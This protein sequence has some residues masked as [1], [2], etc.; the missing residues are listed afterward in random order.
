MLLSMDNNKKKGKEKDSINNNK[1][2]EKDLVGPSIYIILSPNISKRLLV[3]IIKK[4]K[5]KV[6]FY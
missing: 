2:K 3:D 5:D 4:K 1:G 6:M